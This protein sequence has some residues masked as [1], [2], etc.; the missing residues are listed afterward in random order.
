MTDV[1]HD[2]SRPVRVLHQQ[3]SVNLTTTTR[4][5]MLR[6]SVSPRFPAICALQPYRNGGL[7]RYREA[8]LARYCPTSLQNGF[9]W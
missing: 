3:S 9:A 7:I 8:G 4:R 2:K 1:R 5:K 6:M